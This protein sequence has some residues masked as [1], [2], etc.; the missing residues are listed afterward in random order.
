MPRQ[1][2]R[3]HRRGTAYRDTHIYQL[4][5]GHDFFGDAFGDKSFRGGRVNTE[6]M[7]AAWEKF[8]EP[9]LAAWVRE[10]PGTRPFAWWEFDAPEPQGDEEEIDY[11][12]RLGLLESGEQE[13]ADAQLAE[14]DEID[15]LPVDESKWPDHINI[16]TTRGERYRRAMNRSER[17]HAWQ[18]R[19]YAHLGVVSDLA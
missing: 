14:L 11:L 2:R 13:R 19:L 5:T 10:Y 8:S 18:A 1:S 4:L 9:I 17:K 7:Q 16:P 3:A 15:L 12:S 6:A